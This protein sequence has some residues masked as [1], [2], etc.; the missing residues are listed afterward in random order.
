MSFISL[1]TDSITSFVKNP[2]FFLFLKYLNNYKIITIYADINLVNI[3]LI[4]NYFYQFPQEW[5][6]GSKILE[7]Q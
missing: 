3:N 5:K 2:A 1:L 7:T 6:A 4:L